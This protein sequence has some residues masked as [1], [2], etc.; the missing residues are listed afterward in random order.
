M[1]RNEHDISAI[2][3]LTIN[4]AAFDSIRH[5][6]SLKKQA[7]VTDIAKSRATTMVQD[8]E[9]KNFRIEDNDYT[10]RRH[11]IEWHRKYTFSL[12]CLI[13]FFIGAPLGAI[14]RKGGLGLP[15]VISLLLFLFYY[16]I[17]NTNYK[18]ARDG[19]I[20]VWQGTWTSSAILALLGAFFSYKA[21]ND[22]TILEVDTY[23]GV[24]KRLFGKRAVNTFERKELIIYETDYRKAFADANTLTQECRMYLQNCPFPPYFPFWDMQRLNDKL[25]QIVN[26]ETSMVEE[27]ANSRNP[28]IILLLNQLPI[29]PLGRNAA[30]F[31]QKRWNKALGLAFPLGLAW[32]LQARYYDKRTRDD[33]QL[34]SSVCTQLGQAITDMNLIN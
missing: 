18:M 10:R 6:L 15:V 16:V 19:V 9:R 23:I 5:T 22:S 2:Q 13:F 11:L 32:Y 26:I 12:A 31:R 14:I 21:S 24:F 20:S 28:K 33:L 30:P 1:S 8:L 4:A 27:L 17:D 7:E 34:A 3:E 25:R 29:I